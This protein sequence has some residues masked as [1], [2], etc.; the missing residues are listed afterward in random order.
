MITKMKLFTPV[1]LFLLSTV[2]TDA[3]PVVNTAVI[4]D[5]KFAKYR[6][7]PQFNI[8]QDPLRKNLGHEETKTPS[9]CYY[10]KVEKACS[11]T[12]EPL[13]KTIACVQCSYPSKCLG[14]NG[15]SF[16][17]LLSKCVGRWSSIGNDKNNCTCDLL[18]GNY[19]FV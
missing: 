2:F 15:D 16:T 1:L 9:S 3:V 18:S 6:D 19:V 7:L 14:K 5:H 12:E 4:L 8:D 11:D 13:A 10:Y 17:P